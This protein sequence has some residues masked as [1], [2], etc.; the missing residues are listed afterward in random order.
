MAD[1]KGLEI[2]R[3]FDICNNALRASIKCAQEG[4]KPCET[5]K[6]LD[7]CK[8]IKNELDKLWSEKQ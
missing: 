4:Q 6:L 3:V 7:D 1:D 5:C 8:K 2:V